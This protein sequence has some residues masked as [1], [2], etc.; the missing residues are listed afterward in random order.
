MF[1]PDADPGGLPAV[2]HPEILGLLLEMEAELHRDSLFAERKGAG[3]G[4]AIG[5]HHRIGI[6]L[7]P[8]E[9][10]DLG[11]DLEP[12]G[13]VHVEDGA[14]AIRRENQGG[15]G[16]GLG[17]AVFHPVKVGAIDRFLLQAGQ[18]EGAAEAEELFPENSFLLPLRQGEE[19]HFGRLPARDDVPAGIAEDLVGEGAGPKLQGL[20]EVALG[21]HDE[22]D[23]VF[24]EKPM[25]S[26][27]ALARIMWPV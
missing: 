22:G 21:N 5:I 6:G 1:R 18:D 14:V 11:S 27:K 15:P 2:V 24:Q 8:G 9:E 23:S 17:R 10:M 3:R 26:R 12:F 4:N 19:I 25:P 7:V 16:G 13:P 20:A